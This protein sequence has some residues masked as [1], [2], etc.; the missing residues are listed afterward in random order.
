MTTKRRAGG[1]EATEETNKRRHDEGGL[2]E[3]LSKAVAGLPG[4]LELERE[5]EEES[6]WQH[7]AARRLETLPWLQ[8]CELSDVTTHSG[9][10]S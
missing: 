8:R 3:G 2:R 9:G 10:L 1:Q 5:R 7:A 4:W 6:S